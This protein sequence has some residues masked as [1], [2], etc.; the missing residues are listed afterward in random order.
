MTAY[1]I[2]IEFLD[3]HRQVALAITPNTGGRGE[4]PYAL[5]TYLSKELSR[6]IR[7]AEIP[8]MEV[9]FLDGNLVAKI[10]FVGGMRAT[11]IGRGEATT[12]FRLTTAP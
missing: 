4:G 7:N 12:M 3:R 10:E 5:T 2:A 1:Q 11:T 9:C 8:D 6:R